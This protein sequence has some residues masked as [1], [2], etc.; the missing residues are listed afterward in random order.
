MEVMEERFETEK[1]G[2]GEVGESR[3]SSLVSQS[4][5]SLLEDCGF[6]ALG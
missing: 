5:P 2:A 1:A 4:S 3:G 6:S